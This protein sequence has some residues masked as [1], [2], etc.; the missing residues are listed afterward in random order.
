VSELSI[1]PRI[2]TPWNNHH[3]T[4]T[5]SGGY[6]PG[7]SSEKKHPVLFYSITL[8]K[9]TNFNETTDKIANENV[10][11]NSIEIM[12]ILIKYSLLAAM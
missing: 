5:L 9:I 1:T 8:T 4:L 12:C 10:D 2:G 3:Q 6:R 11:S 7:G